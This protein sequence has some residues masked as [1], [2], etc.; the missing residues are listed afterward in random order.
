MG[1]I[2]AVGS[3][4]NLTYT[5]DLRSEGEATGINENEYFRI[6]F[7]TRGKIGKYVLEMPRAKKFSLSEF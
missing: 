3:A 6:K 1:K 7:S 4:N 2:Q 5:K